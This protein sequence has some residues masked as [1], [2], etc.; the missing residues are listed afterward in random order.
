MTSKQAFDELI[1][2]YRKSP[3]FYSVKFLDAN[4]TGLT[5]DTL[6][7]AAVIRGNVTDIDILISAGAKVDI[8]GDL[9]NTPLHHAASRGMVEVTRK[10]LQ[11]DGDPSVRNEFGQIPLDLALLMKHQKVVEML[12]S[13]SLRTRK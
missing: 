1:E 6:L 9:G 5:G 7:H 3:E 13:A 10:L 11:C 2:R 8:A 4:Q 12:K